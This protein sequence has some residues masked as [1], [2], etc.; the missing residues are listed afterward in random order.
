MQLKINLNPNAEWEKNRNGLKNP[1]RYLGRCWK[2][3][4]F[5]QI[6]KTDDDYYQKMRRYMRVSITF[7]YFELAKFLSR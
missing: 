1:P 7:F 3:D 2:D 4:A 6:H 5:C